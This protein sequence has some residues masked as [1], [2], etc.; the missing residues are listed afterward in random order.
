MNLIR[1][2]PQCAIILSA[3][4]G[5]FD[6]ELPWAT[7][8]PWSTGMPISICQFNDK[9]FPPRDKAMT[10]RL[11]PGIVKM[12]GWQV[13]PGFDYYIWVDGSKTITSPDFGAWMMDELGSADMAV[14]KHPERKTI[15]E[16]YEFVKRKLEERNGYLLS[17]YGGEWLDEQYRAIVG[18]R[19]FKDTI[20]YASTAFVYRPN[21]RI[22]AAFKEWWYHKTRYLL[23]D[24]LALPY[25]LARGKVKVNTIDANIYKLSYWEHTRKRR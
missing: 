13:M 11:Q 8:K 3:N 18:D 15:K 19:V 20:L 16:E 12:F 4:L 14:F 2:H 21:A 17:R 7:Q 6:P 22:K 24:Q 9:N 10:S 23:H 25:V 1:K 5:S